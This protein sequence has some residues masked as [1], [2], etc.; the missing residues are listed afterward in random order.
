MA[1]HRQGPAIF[2]LMGDDWFNG[3]AGQIGVD[4]S[5]KLL[6]Q[7][8]RGAQ[9]DVTA[10]FIPL[11]LALVGIEEEHGRGRFGPHHIEVFHIVIG[12]QIIDEL[13]GGLIGGVSLLG[14]IVADQIVAVD[15]ADQGAHQ[16]LGA[17]GVQV[18]HV[19]LI[20]A[21]AGK[22]GGRA[23]HQCHTDDDERHFSP[24]PTTGDLAC[25]S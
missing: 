2:R 22:K 19:G 5:G 23:E 24:Q 17:G 20:G 8:H 14:L 7:L 25:V 11:Y 4:V 13:L 15:L 21:V 9:G 12:H 6:I 1:L 18:G 16:V 10:L 3:L